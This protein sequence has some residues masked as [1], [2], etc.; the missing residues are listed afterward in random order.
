MADEI[1]EATKKYIERGLKVF[2]VKQDKT[3]GTPN[4]F[5]NA[6]GQISEFEKYY[7]P[8]YGIGIPTGHE[9]NIYII[10]LD[11]EKDQSGKPL[12]DEKGNTINTG[13][14]EFCT[15]LNITAPLKE[16]KT[17]VV[18]TQSGGAQIYFKLSP[19]RAILHN[20]TS[21][22]KKVDLRGEGG[23]VVAP[24]SKGS[25]GQYKFLNDS[26]IAF[27]PDNVYNW[28][29]DLELPDDS[30]EI[31]IPLN[32][33]DSGLTKLIKT[34][35]DIFKQPNG[36]GNDLLMAFSGAMAIRNISI[37]HAVMILKES[38]KINKFPESKIN[39]ATVKDSYK[40]AENHSKV[41]GYTTFKK[42]V[43]ENKEKYENYDDIQKNLI[44]I[45]E[46]NR[47]IFYKLNDKGFPVFDKGKSLEFMLSKFPN[48][49][50]DEFGKMYNFSDDGW[51]Q[52]VENE[53]MNFVQSLDNTLSEHAINEIIAG[54]KHITYNITF[55]EKKLPNTF[56]PI[57]E[58]L[59]NVETK[60]IDTHNVNYFYSNIKRKYIPGI[61]ESDLAISDF[62]NHILENPEKDK[63]TIYQ[64][65]AWGLLNKN[66]IQGMGILFG[67]GGNGKGILQNQVIA[68]LLG[69]ENVALPDLSRI[70]NYDFELQSLINKK[71]LLFSES[72]KGISYNWEKLKRITGH[73]YENIPIKNKPP[74]QYQYASAVILS[75]NSLIPPRDELAIWRRI[76]FIVE[77]NNYLNT[78]TSDQIS[79]IVEKISNGDEL[80][81]LFS[82]ILD[83]IYPSFAK[84]GFAYR[85]SI[86][87][88]KT[89][90]LMKS[91]PAI[92][93]LQLKEQRNEIL[94]DPEEVLAY[95]TANNYDQNMCYFVDKSGNQTIYQIK[96][97]LIKYINK[98]CELNKL[99]QYDVHDRLSQTKIGQ[100]IHYLNIEVS[101]FQKRMNGNKIHAW[102]GIF[103][104]P[105]DTEIRLEEGHDGTEAP[106]N[107]QVNSKP[108][109]NR[110]RADT[111]GLPPGAVKDELEQYKADKEWIR[112]HEKELNAN[113]GGKHHEEK[114]KAE[115]VETLP[116]TANYD[117]NK[118]F[119]EKIR[120]T[121]ASEKF[122]LDGNTGPSF[123]KKDFQ[124]YVHPTELSME[125]FTSLKA[126]MK[127]FGFKY[128][129]IQDPYGVRFIRKIGGVSNE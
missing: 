31:K 113:D 127:G 35:A 93:Y 47:M 99:P 58:G 115:S 13:E 36:H 30:N 110:E 7:R 2:P 56:I 112:E 16:L 117:I 128:S 45:F 119:I 120:E 82:F 44:D 70:A 6:A 122:I 60:Q 38:A 21:V 103:V 20:H 24:P 101:D 18:K 29:L 114:K 3:P 12:L 73:D 123:D 17:T 75:T 11:V 105:D 19:N 26:G 95:C 80:D 102:T 106:G 81:R 68:K 74:L 32:L 5:K 67:E 41:L 59:Y 25:Y 79:E 85:F 107:N 40:R 64:A 33:N 78:L 96:E 4:G 57:T 83:N 43:Q 69:H 62:L 91:N 126:I 104:M 50:T 76:I 39:F 121:L 15:Q 23:Y 63:L 98:F 54:L 92:T 53:L 65:I 1:I 42:L 22:L 27:M 97:I 108:I 66:Y 118:D 52:D 51:H 14:I 9:N 88:A 90:Y 71:C 72:V 89:Q 77:F 111:T 49:K 10:D 87:E 86:K 94:R 48:L 125:R 34:L 109:E 37:N 100:A 84:K 46:K 116:D 55:K 28:W 61:N 129:L 124:L 8:G